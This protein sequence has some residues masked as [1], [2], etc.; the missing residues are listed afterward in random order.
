MKDPIPQFSYIIEQL[1]NRFPQL[2]YLHIVEPDPGK[3]L[4]SQS[5]IIRNLWA[6]RP[7]LSCNG[8]D[9]KTARQVALR[10]ENEVVV[11]G[12][13]FISNVKNLRTNIPEYQF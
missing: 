3:G 4:E 13:H 2:A 7:L 5:D 8:H 9:V 6:P 10:S 11:F 1:K 12:R